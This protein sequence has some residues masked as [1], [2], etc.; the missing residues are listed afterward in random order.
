MEET[1]SPGDC[2]VEREGRRYL[3]SIEVVNYPQ[4]WDGAN[5]AS[6]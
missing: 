6:L 1:P 4:R 2:R 5:G 3:T